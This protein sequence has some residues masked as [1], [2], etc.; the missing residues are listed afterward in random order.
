MQFAMLNLYFSVSVT[1]SQL[2]AVPVDERSYDSDVW[3]DDTLTEDKHTMDAFLLELVGQCMEPGAVAAAQFLKGPVLPVQNSLE[4]TELPAP[5][6]PDGLAAAEATSVL[7]PPPPA[8]PVSQELAPPEPAAAVQPTSV[9]VVEPAAAEPDAEPQNG[10]T[11]SAAHDEA[12]APMQ[13]AT[14]RKGKATN[15]KEGTKKRQRVAY[16]V[17]KP[18]SPGGDK[19]GSVCDCF[20]DGIDFAKVPNKDAHAWLAQQVQ[21]IWPNHIRGVKR[22]G[23]RCYT[24]TSTCGASLEVNYHQKR[25]VCQRSCSLE[26]WEAGKVRSIRSVEDPK[27]S[28]DAICKLLCP[29]EKNFCKKA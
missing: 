27:A 10:S 6:A 19:C 5:P 7:L 11:S 8:A 20:R 21:D 17:G 29:C 15:E 13:D 18:K 3:E 9:H 14:N 26:F 22:T 1:D 12:V 28:F 25:L 2:E 24:L 16:R 23:T 4:E